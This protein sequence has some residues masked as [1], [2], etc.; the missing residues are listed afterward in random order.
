M[1]W[2]LVRNFRTYFLPFIILFFSSCS[3][4]SPITL[5]SLLKE[6]TDRTSLTYFPVNQFTHRQFSSYNRSSVSPDSTGW[7]ANADMSHFLSVEENKGRREF[8]M[9]DTDGPGAIVR[10]WMTF[11]K[12]QNGILRVYID[13]NSVPVIEGLPKD[14]LR[15]TLVSNPP[16]AVSVQEGA[17]LGEEGRDYDH[18]F[19]VPIPFAEHCKITY[20]CD[21]LR[22][23]Y[24]YEGIKVP[25]GYY[26]PDVFYNIGYRLYSRKTTVISLTK[27]SLESARTLFDKAGEELMDETI[28]SKSEEKTGKIVLP[29]DSIVVPVI[30]ENSAVSRLVVMLDAADMNQSLRSTVIKISFDG[31]TTV[32]SPLGDF[33]GAGYTLY[34]HRTWMNKTDSTGL[35]ESCWVMPFREKC[36][37]K[38]IN[39]GSDTIHL[40]VITGVSD[41]QWKKNSMYF[42]ASW[43]EY[44]RIRTRSDSGSPYDLNFIDIR[45]KGVYA[46]DQVTL[47]NDTY[48]W[49]GEGDEKI[50]VDGESFPS[51]FGTGSEDY[52][53]YSFARREAFSHPFISQPVGIGNMSWGV[54]INMRHRSLDAIPFTKSISSNIELWHWADIK[55]NYALTTYYYVQNP[56]ETN[57][58]PD[59]EGVRRKVIISR[60]DFRS[61]ENNT[62]KPLTTK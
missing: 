15:G 24:D 36:I 46:G 50:F 57:I 14:I 38:M 27:E 5:E 11:Y 56:Y 22:L 6:M 30:Q 32:W 39:Y 16:L 48:H 34:P 21:S 20:E 55:M 51:I 23:L 62:D 58:K 25:Q 60:N 12:A 17:P 7:F 3:N 26:W 54:T 13:N 4:Y 9:F 31:N 1:S 35:M 44:N 52:Y 33:F 10:W 42:G 53:G 45:G 28:I 18:N 47:Y 29:G 49:W 8:V 61:E 2:Y 37:I 59:I 19:Y 41:Y 43:H 40:D